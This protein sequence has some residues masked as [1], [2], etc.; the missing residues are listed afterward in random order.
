MW[1]LE[2][3]MEDDDGQPLQ[4]PL[5]LITFL[6]QILSML[7]AVHTSLCFEYNLSTFY[8]SS[9]KMPVFFLLDTVTHTTTGLIEHS[10]YKPILIANLQGEFIRYC[11]VL[12]HFF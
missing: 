10:C 2:K 5:M 11:L 6:S 8:S 3:N 12:C 4:S 1:Y 9:T 7:I